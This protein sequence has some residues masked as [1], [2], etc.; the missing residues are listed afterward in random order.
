MFT[1]KVIISKKLP[2]NILFI[3]EKVKI[4]K[5]VLIVKKKKLTL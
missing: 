1:I 3:K 4:I 5:I 2:S